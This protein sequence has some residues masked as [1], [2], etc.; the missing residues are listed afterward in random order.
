MCS[1][2]GRLQ[3]VFYCNCRDEPDVSYLWKQKSAIA[4]ADRQATWSSG[5]S[6]CDRI[7]GVC[8]SS[9]LGTQWQVRKGKLDGHGLWNPQ[10]IGMWGKEGCNWW[11]VAWLGRSPRSWFAVSKRAEKSAPFLHF[12]SSFLCNTNQSIIKSL[13]YLSGPGVVLGFHLYVWVPGAE[14]LFEYTVHTSLSLYNS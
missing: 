7:G 5:N 6:T 12:S 14:D 1:R 2:E 4:Q 11:L 3:L 13:I 10:E 9:G 8:L